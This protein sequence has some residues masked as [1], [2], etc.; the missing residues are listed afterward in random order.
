MSSS[1]GEVKEFVPCPRFA[2]CKRT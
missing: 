1:R 2:E